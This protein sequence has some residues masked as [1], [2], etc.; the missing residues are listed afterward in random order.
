MLAE[1][2]LGQMAHYDNLTSLPNRTLF[3]E[4]LQDALQ[5]AK[6]CDHLVA[7]LVV[8]LDRFKVINDTLGHAAGD[9]VLI[10]VAKRLATQIRQS[11]TIARLGGDEFAVI[12][13]ITENS[14]D[15]ASVALKLIESLNV[16][17]HLD[18]QE[19]FVSVSIGIALQGPEVKDPDILLR[20]A[21]R[22]M[23]RAK[24]LGRNNYQ[25]FR[26]ELD[27]TVGGQ[28]RLETELRRAL[29]HGQFLLF[30]QPKVS[31]K[32]GK[33][34]G[35]EALLRWQHP[36]RG[37]VSP[38]EFVPA[39]EETG[40]ILQVGNWSLWTACMQAQAWHAAGLAE[41]SVAVN[42]SARQL[43]A[44]GLED[45]VRKALSESGLDPCY[46]ELEITESML[47][48]NV[49]QAIATLTRL[50]SMGIGLSI[51]DFGTGYSSLSYLKRFPLDS[52]KVDRSF[53]QDI[54][55]DANDASITRAVI[56]MAHRLQLNVV[57]EGVETRGQL[58]MLIR[59]KCD[60]IQGYFFSKPVPANELAQMVRQGKCLDGGLIDRPHERTL[61]L[62]DDEHDILR[63]LTRLFRSDGYR[64]LV[65]ASGQEGLEILAQERVD[66]VVS[67][68]RMPGMNGV[69]F[70]RRTKELHPSAIRII[71]SAYSDLVS[72]TEAINEGAIYKF[73]TKPWDNGNLRASIDEAFRRK[74]MQDENR[75]LQLNVQHNNRELKR[76]NR[77]LR[78]LLQKR[79]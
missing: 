79:R 6:R 40:L 26:P 28:L 1:K 55:V 73:L 44:P 11:D 21:D 56:A 17:L 41:L 10:Q 63:A 69:Q 66:V 18:G 4:R 22:A 2:Q 8:A 61:L 54:T 29:Q 77:R 74:E 57:A 76:A 64:I 51:D 43:Y 36:E 30:Y 62:V 68:Q 37:L 35:A 34:V 58:A 39:L 75:R 12:L 42:L 78:S 52:L 24:E 13:P 70:L 59:N 67:D 38:Q 71:L 47:M 16:P 9:T 31:C 53:V 27:K 20:N 7:V 14:L 48:Q 49:H 46:L 72:I 19:I 23:Y 5:F 45:A 25:F 32:S 50:K 33:I 3:R 65:A 15:A 60:V